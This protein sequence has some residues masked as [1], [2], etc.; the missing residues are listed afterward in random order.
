MNPADG[1]RGVMVMV[2]GAGGGIYGPAGTYEDLLA[3][4]LQADGAATLRLRYREPNN[5][6][7]CTYDT[8]I[9]AADALG[10][11]SVERVVLLGW[12]FGSAGVI[13]AGAASDAVVGGPPSRARRTVPGP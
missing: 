6:D 11:Q 10:G 13:S 3:G 1:A 2:G 8:T 9:A 5:L 7:E 4:R 12:S